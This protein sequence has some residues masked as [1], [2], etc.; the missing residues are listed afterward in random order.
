MKYC[1][2]SRIKISIFPYF[3]KVENSNFRKMR[4]LLVLGLAFACASGQFFNPFSLFN[5][6]NGNRRPPPPAQRPS[7]FSSRPVSAPGPAPSSGGN[8]RCTNGF[9]VSGQKFTWSGARN[10][11]TRN[12]MRPSSLENGQKVNIA[13]GLVRPL[14]YFWTGGQVNHSSRTVSWPNGASSTPDWSPTGG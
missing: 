14:K 9:H 10:Y 3:K 11:C 6:G 8:G 13:Y 1:E 12:G 7:S 4:V 5:R 2:S